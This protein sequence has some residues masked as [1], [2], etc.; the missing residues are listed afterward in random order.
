MNICNLNLNLTYCYYDKKK[1]EE[2][3]YRNEELIKEY[4]EEFEDIAEIIYQNELLQVFDL[5]EFDE[6]KINEKIKTLYELLIQNN[7]FKRFLEKN[8]KHKLDN[9]LQSKFILLF[10]YDYFHIFYEILREYLTNNKLSDKLLDRLR[11]VL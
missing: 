11:M 8:V 9:N 1:R 2:M 3:N 4:L 10:N 6:N 7:E 5:I